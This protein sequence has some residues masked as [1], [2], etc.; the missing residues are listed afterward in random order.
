MSFV[1]AKQ[2]VKFL[3]APIRLNNLSVTGSSQTVTSPLTA[4]LAS[5]GDGGVSVPL[6]PAGNGVG[7]AVT[8]P[9]NRCKVYGAASEDTLLDNGLE[10]QARL[11][12]S[13]G[14]YT[15]AFFTVSDAGTETAYSFPAATPIDV[16]FNYRFDFWRIPADAIVA[17][18]VRSMGNDPTTTAARR[19]SERLTIG[20]ANTIP[21]LSKTPTSAA[22][23][24]LIVNGL[25]YDS[26]GG[27]GA[28]FSVNTDTKAIAWSA[29][30]AGIS[31]E[32]SDRVIARYST[33]ET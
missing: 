29:A 5:A 23:V 28:F 17:T 14:V 24:E 26:F 33:I 18:T 2:I 6:Q 7:V 3:F 25:S 31:I 1:Q 15:L 9:H 27:S 21:N 8:P 20:T 13:N 12:E 22:D 4:A 19:F 32:P 16:E 11:T 10:I 30:N